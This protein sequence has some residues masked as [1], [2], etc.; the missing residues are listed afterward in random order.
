[1]SVIDWLMDKR[2]TNPELEISGP[3]I[4]KKAENFATLHGFTDFK[5]TSGWFDRWKKQYQMPGE[6]EKADNSVVENLL[7]RF[8]SIIGE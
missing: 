7:S 1:M 3:V 8:K 2:A 5:P 4:L 6:S